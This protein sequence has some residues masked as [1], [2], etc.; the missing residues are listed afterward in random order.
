MDKLELCDWSLELCFRTKGSIS[1]SW[2]IATLLDVLHCPRLFFNIL[3]EF[4]TPVFAK[5][6]NLQYI[7]TR[8]LY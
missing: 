3:R 7:S 2:F 4:Q 5:K 6:T 1:L 8:L